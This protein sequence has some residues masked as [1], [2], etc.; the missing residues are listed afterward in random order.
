MSFRQPSKRSF[1]VAVG[2]ATAVLVGVPAAA[3]VPGTAFVAPVPISLALLCGIAATV[4]A[5]RVPSLPISL[6]RAR[7]HLGVLAVP[8]GVVVV[9]PFL[10]PALDLSGSPDD[11]LLL[12]LLA[13]FVASGAL[14]VATTNRYAVLLN[15]AHSPIAEWRARP[16]ARYSRRVRV[17]SFVGGI[18]ALALPLLVHLPGVRLL[19]GIGGVLIAQSI[20]YRRS[21]TYQLFDDGLLIRASGTVVYQFVPAGQLSSVKR[22]PDAISIRR[23][24]PWPFPIR[25]AVDELARPDELLSTLRDAIERRP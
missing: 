4:L 7:V 9:A 5:L 23:S 21:R 10:F 18:A 19:P 13:V 11:G 1:A 12:G 24:L 14:Y 20:F 8:L 22:G 17:A 2:T 25:C 3:V 15:A 6:V 16:D